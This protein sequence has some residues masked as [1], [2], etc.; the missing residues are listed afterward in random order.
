MIDVPHVSKWSWRACIHQVACFLL[1]TPTVYI[2]QIAAPPSCTPCTLRPHTILLDSVS[3]QIRTVPP[4]A[5]SASNRSPE[6]PPPNHL[7][8]K[9]AK[10]N[11]SRHIFRDF[12]SAV[13]EI[14]AS[15][16]VPTTNLRYE[17]TYK[18]NLCR[19]DMYWSQQVELLHPDLIHLDLVG[20]FDIMVQHREVVIEWMQRH[21][22]RC[23][24]P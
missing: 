12:L 1:S 17:E 6:Q 5:S 21:T 19:Q 20:H 23:F 8:N 18:T 14:M 16:R 2:P 13:K 22:D 10:A 4:P 9:R 15:P 11:E 24:I 3:A 7:S